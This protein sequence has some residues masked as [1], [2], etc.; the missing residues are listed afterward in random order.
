[1]DPVGFTA[2]IITLGVFAGQVAQGIDKL[3]ELKN[4][5]NEL[6]A[7]LGT[8][9]EFRITLDLVRSSLQSLQSEHMPLVEPVMQPACQHIHRLLQQASEITNALEKLVTE[10]LQKP[11]KS[12]GGSSQEGNVVKVAKWNYLRQR[13]NLVKMQDQMKGLVRGLSL[14]LTTLNSL[15]LSHMQRNQSANLT[16][17]IQEISALSSL[18]KDE[19]DTSTRSLDIQLEKTLQKAEEQ[20]EAR[21]AILATPGN[22][23]SRSA[24]PSRRNSP[25]SETPSLRISMKVEKER[26]LPICPCQCHF[27]SLIRTPRWARIVFGTFVHQS[28]NRPCNLASCKRSRQAPT[29][30]TYITPRWAVQRALHI[31][32]GTYDLFGLSPSIVI[33]F[34]RVISEDTPAWDL[35]SWRS[36]NIDEFRQLLMERK[37]SPFDVA[38]DGDSLLQA[39]QWHEPGICEEL[40]RCGADPY[41]CGTSG[42]PAFAYGLEC[43]LRHGGNRK[44]G[45]ESRVA[46]FERLYSDEDMYEQLALTPLH[47]IIISADSTESIKDI[48]LHLNDLN[49]TDIFGRT[50]LSWAASQGDAKNLK[51]LISYGSQVNK[52][53]HW[54]MTPLWYAVYSG[55]TESVQIL[56]LA[57]ADASSLDH[58]GATVIHH[59]MWSGNDCTGV[60]NLLMAYDINLEARDI[61]GRTPLHLAAEYE[62]ADSIEERLN[63]VK[64]ILQHGA[65]IDALD[66]QGNSATLKACFWNRVDLLSLL[67]SAGAI[68]DDE[69]EHGWNILHVVAWGANAKVMR[70]L[71]DLASHGRMTRINLNA[72]HNGHDLWT[73][74][75]TCRRKGMYPEARGDG[76]RERKAFEDLLDIVRQFQ[77]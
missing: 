3:V 65:M 62:A 12:S 36:S 48:T 77:P 46:H 74:F 43:V 34:P 63:N 6:Q 20:F 67:A 61:F 33:R 71:A 23:S 17:V 57:G 39:S 54:N 22:N 19:R 56:L 29:Y 49:R 47:R 27:Q 70:T 52:S 64:C 35:I 31:A 7:I 38:E 9:S 4:A 24:A 53:D 1:M 16:V 73:C 26:C 59:A 75:D 28:S 37:I 41:Y 51:T 25:F 21:H 44:M 2:S 55:D 11:A 40:L 8:V 42:V 15:Q 68:L 69:N 13:P 14:A 10:K 50:P 76:E 5:P 58:L 66:N 72:K 30:F 60:I 18:V 32:F 45:L